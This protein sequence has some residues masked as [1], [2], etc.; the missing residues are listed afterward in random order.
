MLREVL[1]QLA[2]QQRKDSAHIDREKTDI[3][4]DLLVIARR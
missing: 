4:K 3:D 2:E 1:R